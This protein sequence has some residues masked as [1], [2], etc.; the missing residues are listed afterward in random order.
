MSTKAKTFF[1]KNLGPMTFGTFLTGMRTTL[2]MS[3]SELAKKLKV[4]RSMICDIEK[5]RV[6]VAP[7]LAIKYCLQDLLIKKN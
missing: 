3:Q 1:E 6:F 7:T 4:S 5:G 2:D